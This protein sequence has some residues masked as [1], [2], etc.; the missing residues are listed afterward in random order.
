[1]TSFIDTHCHLDMLK[2]S[3]SEALQS[4]HAAGVTRLVTISTNEASIRFVHETARSQPHVYGSVGVHPHEAA[5]FSA[6]IAT[7]IRETAKSTSKIVAIGEMGLD[8][9]YMY[10]EKLVQHNVFREQLQVAEELQMPVVLHTRE[11]EADTLA[12]LKEV[13]ITKKGVAHSFTSS[14]AM[15]ETLIEMGW[16]IGIN[17]IATFKKAE[18]VRQVARQIP[19]ER[20]LLETDSPFLAPVP[21]RGKPNDPSKIP[22]IAEFLAKELDLTTEEL[23]AQTTA[24][25]QRLFDFQAVSQEVSDANP[26]VD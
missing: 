7:L 26:I 2:L 9:H 22:A 4:A 20:L 5:T 25:A 6:D 19:I 24:N 11:A 17:G 18:G 10:S 3:M 14:L 13:P 15:A 21:F 23:A 1:M 16:Y 8:Y 12:I